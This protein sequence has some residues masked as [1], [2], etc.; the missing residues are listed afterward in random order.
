[1][2]DRSM[3][4]KTAT[5]PTLRPAAPEAPGRTAYPMPLVVDLVK[6]VVLVRSVGGTRLHGPHGG[7]CGH[8]AHRPG[9]LA[10]GGAELAQ[11]PD[12]A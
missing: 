10:R 1:M 6:D 7:Y 4:H 2:G 5:A 9:P 8:V 3:A 12:G 11:G